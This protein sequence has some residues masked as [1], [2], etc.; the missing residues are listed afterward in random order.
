MKLFHNYAHVGLVV[1]L[2]A[3]GWYY[4]LCSRHECMRG[5][6]SDPELRVQHLQ[7]TYWKLQSVKQLL[8]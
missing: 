3:F 8:K 1:K 4:A 7:F 6:R 2:K 5:G